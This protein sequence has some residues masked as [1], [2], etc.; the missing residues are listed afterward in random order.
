MSES[1]ETKKLTKGVRATVKKNVPKTAAEI[2]M[3]E[4]IA[5]PFTAIV[6]ALIAIPLAITGPRARFNRGLLFSILVLFVFYILRA[7]AISI[8]QAEIV[9]PLL[10]AWL[11]NIILFSLG[12]YMYRL[13]AYHI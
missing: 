2:L 11:P 4:K 8:G 6:F 3:N 10:A 9:P 7:L 1:V 5:L 12:Y 13:K